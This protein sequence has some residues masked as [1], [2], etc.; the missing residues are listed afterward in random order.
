MMISLVGKEEQLLSVFKKEL[1]L[2]LVITCVS[3][4]FPSDSFDFKRKSTVTTI[5]ED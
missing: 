3:T 2:D 1:I 5:K 4:D